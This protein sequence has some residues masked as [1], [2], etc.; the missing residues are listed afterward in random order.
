MGTESLA[1]A[2]DLGARGQGG[3]GAGARTWGGP[4]GSGWSYGEVRW[5]GAGL[6]GLDLSGHRR[7]PWRGWDGKRAPR[8]QMRGWGAVVERGEAGEVL[9][10]AREW[11]GKVSSR[12]PPF[13]LGQS[14]GDGQ[15]SW[16]GAEGNR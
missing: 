2:V 12:L 13:E 8:A 1:T 6:V 3:S 7:R 15:Q 5:E 10:R 16:V 14:S 4:P 11:W 9:G